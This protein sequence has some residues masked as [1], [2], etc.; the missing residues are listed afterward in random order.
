VTPPTEGVIRF[1]YEHE[2]A[3]L[4][5]EARALLEELLPWR[6]RLREVGWL[7][8]DP[9]RYDGYG[10]GNLSARLE[11][12]GF[13]ISGTQTSGLEEAGEESFCVVRRW[14]LEDNRVASAGPVAPSSESLSHAALYRARDEIRAVLHVHA[15]ELF[16]EAEHKGLPATG[17]A[18]EA[19]TVE[20]ARDLLRLGAVGEPC[21][22]IRMAGHPD[23]L[24][25]YGRSAAEAAAR[26][27]LV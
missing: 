7:G 1:T 15:P 22:L 16:E 11:S 9:G 2:T 5:S 25:A 4:P 12:G 23:G 8:Q 13:V 14:W 10:Y 17:P 3:P 26:L 18:A 19:G 27:G 6:R 21:G 20:I 24:L